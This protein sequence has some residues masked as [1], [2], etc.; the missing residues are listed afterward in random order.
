MNHLYIGLKK[1]EDDL[2]NL[3]KDEEKKRDFMDYK[4]CSQDSS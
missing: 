2:K 3:P 1:I 4:K